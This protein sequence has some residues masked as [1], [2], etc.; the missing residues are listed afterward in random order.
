VNCHETQPFLHAYVD[1]ELDLMKALEV[2][3]HLQECSACAYRRDGLQALRTK[4]Q[5]ELPVYAATNVLR[6]QVR[7]ALRKS[8][9]SAARPR[10]SARRWRALAACVAVIILL[11]PALVK[12]SLCRRW[13]PRTLDESPE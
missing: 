6:S 11:T 5:T 13:D 7:T 1:S 4:L 3:Q 2:E 9:P 8:A 10:F 12:T